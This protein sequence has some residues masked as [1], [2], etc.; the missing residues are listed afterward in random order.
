[1]DRFLFLEIGLDL[2]RAG[3]FRT[4]AIKEGFD[5]GRPE[6]LCLGGGESKDQE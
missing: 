6:R 2:G 3:A 4:N 1:M 5:F